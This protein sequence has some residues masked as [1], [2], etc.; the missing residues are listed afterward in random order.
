[1]RKVLA[2]LVV[3]AVV[4]CFVPQRSASGAT[5]TF[6]QGSGGYGGCVDTYVRAINNGI[7]LTYADQN[8]GAAQTLSVKREHWL[9]GS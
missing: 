1:M 7:S 5:A 8:Y 4:F 9:D 2:G 6:Q 3:A